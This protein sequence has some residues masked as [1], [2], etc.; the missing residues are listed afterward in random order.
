MTLL[1]ELKFLVEKLAS[2]DYGVSTKIRRA[3]VGAFMNILAK[4]DVFRPPKPKLTLT[5]KSS[6]AKVDI[7]TDFEKYIKLIVDKASAKNPDKLEVELN[8]L[9]SEA[10]FD[11]SDIE[12]G[13]F[14]LE[15]PELSKLPIVLSDL[16]EFLL[17]LV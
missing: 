5:L 16:A 13:K 10:G 2:E 17:N 8:R 12:E 11:I 9:E 1:G 7:E 3:I 4:Q 14:Y 15:L 6:G